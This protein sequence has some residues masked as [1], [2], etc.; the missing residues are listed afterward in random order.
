MCWTTSWHSRRCVAEQQATANARAQQVL[1]V[2]T[3]SSGQASD[4]DER[5]SQ[6]QSPRDAPCT[7]PIM[8]GWCPGERPG[9]TPRKTSL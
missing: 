5:R 7:S 9:A 3:A 8:A 6:N 1:D 4:V 2:L